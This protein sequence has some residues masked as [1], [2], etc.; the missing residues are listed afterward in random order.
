[1]ALPQE[2][3]D[4]TLL[5]KSTQ[6]ELREHELAV[7]AYLEGPSSRLHELSL[8]TER[9]L[10]FSRQTGGQRTV[11]SLNAILD[12][13]LHVSSFGNLGSSAGWTRI[14]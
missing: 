11:A 10:E 7:P 6:G 4:L 2:G 3:W 13:Y 12:G 8:D 14:S 1:L 5:G 9:C